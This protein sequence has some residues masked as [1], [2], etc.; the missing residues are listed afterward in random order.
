[1]TVKIRYS[2]PGT[3]A[4]LIPL[5][6]D[7]ALVRLNE[8]Q[9]AVTPG[10]RSAMRAMSSSQEAGFAATPQLAL[11]PNEAMAD[12]ALLVFSTFRMLPR[13]GVSGGN[14]WRNAAPPAPTYCRRSSR[15]I[16]GRRKSRV[17]MRHSFCLRRVPTAVSNALSSQLHPYDAGNH[18][19]SS[20]A[21]AAGIPALGADEL[22]GVGPTRCQEKRG[23]KHLLF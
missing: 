15:S 18:F 19:V 10:Q 9:K 22:C 17:R 12:E 7:R 11:L 5:D 8:P 16:G 1:M 2:H 3:T 14:W 6:G 13:P 4:T 21:R 23:R 20:R